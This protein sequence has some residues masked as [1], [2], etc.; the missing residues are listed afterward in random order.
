MRSVNWYVYYNS[1]GTLEI[2]MNINSPQAR[3]I[4]ENKYVMAFMGEQDELQAVIVIK[5]IDKHELIL[6]GRTLNWL[7]EKRVVEPFSERTRKSL[8]EVSACVPDYM[9]FY[10]P[11]DEVEE[12]EEKIERTGM[13][14]AEAAVS[15][16]L[17]L[18]GLGH[19]VRWDYGDTAP[20][21]NVLEGK[22][23][24]LFFSEDYCN[25]YDTTYTD[26]LLDYAS[27]GYYLK[28]ETWK[29]VVKDELDG[30]KLF[31]S[32]LSSDT[33]GEARK[34]LEDLRW[35][36]TVE[37]LTKRLRYKENYELG[38]IINMKFERDGFLA[39]SKKRITGVHIWYEG[40]DEG[41][42]PV[43]EDVE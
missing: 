24:N 41:E 36:N 21:F 29:S 42:E 35:K 25:I 17:G 23:N 20:C 28:N 3:T 26:D 9:D 27:K 11:I 31:E 4:L 14:T 7:L 22:D 40:E 19:E 13:E 8:K 12:K 1:V 18:I 30:M 33:K 34:E 6:F 5:K 2:H 16:I 38:D 15:G 32:V 43:F 39:E 37:G 10:C